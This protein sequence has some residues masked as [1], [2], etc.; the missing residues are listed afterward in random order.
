MKNRSER[1]ELEN[2][3]NAASEVDS[4]RGFSVRSVHMQ[5]EKR[6]SEQQGTPPKKKQQ[7]PARDEVDTSRLD[8][9]FDEH[10]DKVTALE[11]NQR[12]DKMRNISEERMDE[13]LRRMGWI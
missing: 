6:M 4:E 7:P 13:E 12:V 11:E 8:R 5:P 3:M 1:E 10:E 9:L 2:L